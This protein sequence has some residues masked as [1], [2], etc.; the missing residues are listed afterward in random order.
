MS[1]A[2][3]PKPTVF[4]LPVSE[5][6]FGWLLCVLFLGYVSPFTPFSSLDHV[7]GSKVVEGAVVVVVVVVVVVAAAIDGVVV[8]VV[9]VAATEGRIGEEGIE[10]GGEI[11][12]SGYQ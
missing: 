3:S 7:I 9:V 2:K 4:K 6:S 10:G 8:V 1:N 12:S 11:S 5:V